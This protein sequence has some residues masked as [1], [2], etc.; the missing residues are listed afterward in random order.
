MARGSVDEGKSASVP[1]SPAA[2]GRAARYLVMLVVLQPALQ[3]SSVGPGVEA[4]PLQALQ[5]SGGRRPRRHH[6][7]EAVVEG[8]RVL[9]GPLVLCTSQGTP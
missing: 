7:V 8:C 5:G 2:W 3:V 9:V 4:A 1:A 6:R